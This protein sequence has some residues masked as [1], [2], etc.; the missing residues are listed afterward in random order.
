MIIGMIK[1]LPMKIGWHGEPFAG[2]R[3]DGLAD[4]ITGEA[5]S[6]TER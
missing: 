5:S 3:S 1:G 6:P 2:A 4:G